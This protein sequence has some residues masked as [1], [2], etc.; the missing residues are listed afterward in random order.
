[1]TDKAHVRL[2]YS[3][4]ESICGRDNPQVSPLPSLLNIVALLLAQARMIE[5]GIHSL[6]H[7][8]RGDVP[9]RLSLPHIYDTRSG[10]SI[11]EREQGTELILGIAHDIR[12]VGTLKSGTDDIVLPEAELLLDIL[13][14]IRSGRCSKRYH[15]HIWKQ[16]PDI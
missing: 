4:P 11:A 16:F 6:R 13:R 9:G 12:Q 14:D 7:Q 5:A 8:K 10:H 15:R 2:V 1:M 3:H